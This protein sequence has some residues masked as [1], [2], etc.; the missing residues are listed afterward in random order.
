[1][2]ANDPFE[3]GKNRVEALSD[4]LFAIAM[5]ILVLGF[6]LPTLPASAP[7]VQVAPAIWLMWPAL[8]TYTVAFIGIGVYW[9]LH[10]MVFHAVRVVDGVLLWLNIV[11]FLF[12]SILPFSVQLVDQFPRAQVTPVLLGANLAL[13]GWLLYAQWVYALSRPSLLV[14]HLPSWYRDSVGLRVTVAPVAATLTTFICFWSVSTSLAVYAL[15]LPFYFLP[16]KPKKSR[17]R[18]SG[19]G[20]G[21]EFSAA[22]LTP[23]RVLIGGGILAALVAWF[24]FRPELLFVNQKVNEGLATGD[25]HRLLSGEF[26]GLAHETS[27][28]AEV[29]EIGG[30][31]VLRFSG[32]S[33]SNG[34]DVHVYL[35]DA[36]DASSDDTV[37]HAGFINLGK[38][39]GNQGDQNYDLP[40][41]TDLTAYRSVSLWCQRF[42]VNFG[43]CS[44]R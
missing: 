5:T 25:A 16:L 6:K 36:L 22:I 13:V 21:Q 39:K 2:P 28:K 35:V 38:L 24:L 10:H 9:I 29:Y 26:K 33:T 34:P 31:L 27:G 41:G 11:F 40:S 43:A 20:L 7:N 15:L 19:D 3:L 4:G 30:H 42:N 17:H 37:R 44:L 12:I 1:M 14:E 23:R 32:F 18:E 8:L